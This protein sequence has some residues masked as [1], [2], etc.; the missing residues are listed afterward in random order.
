[1]ILTDKGTQCSLLLVKNGA[2]EYGA[3]HVGRDSEK[4]PDAPGGGLLEIEEEHD[5]KCENF[6]V[7]AYINRDKKL[8]AVAMDEGGGKAQIISVEIEIAA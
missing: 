5:Q 6:K 1:M 2:V 3:Q 7:P 4:Q 8:R